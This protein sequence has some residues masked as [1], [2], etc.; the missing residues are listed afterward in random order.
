MKTPNQIKALQ[1]VEN[2]MNR[3]LKLSETSGLDLNDTKR[4][5]TIF[6]LHQILTDEPTAIVSNQSE[7]ASEADILKVLKGGKQE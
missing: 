1:I 6:K 7:N 3:L 4:L 5:D 2:E